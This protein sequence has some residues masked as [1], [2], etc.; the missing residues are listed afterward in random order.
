MIQ[1]E[2]S[3][4]QATLAQ[5]Y[6][7]IMGFLDSIQSNRN[8]GILVAVTVTLFAAGFVVSQG[9]SR[10]SRVVNATVFTGNS[11][12]I[13]EDD[14]S[15]TGYELG[16]R[17]TILPLAG[18]DG[19][20]WIVNAQQLAAEG[21]CRIRET[22]FDNAPYGREVH[23]SQC[24]IWWMVT[25]GKIHSSLT[26]MSHARSI[27]LM[28]IFST[29]LIFL[30]FIG[31]TAYLTLRRFGAIPAALV[32]LLVV[33]SVNFAGMFQVA[34]P[35]H[36]GIA[37]AALFYCVMLIAFAL[38]G[39]RIDS[40]KRRKIVY[41]AFFVPPI[42]YA[43]SRSYFLASGVAG[44]VALWISASTTI[45]ALIG[46]GGGALA[47]TL[48]QHWSDREADSLAS[49]TLLWRTWSLAGGSVSLLLYLMEYFPY[50][51]GW[52]LEVNHPIYSLAW[53]AAGELLFQTSTWIRQ[54]VNPLA[55]TKKLVVLF[56]AMGCVLLP[57][58]MIC[59][60]PQ[61]FFVVRDPFLWQLHSD[62][63]FEFAPLIR[64]FQAD[65]KIFVI[66]TLL[67][68]AFPIAF[69]FRTMMFEAIGSLWKRTLWFL[70][71]PSLI[72]IGLSLFQIRWLGLAELTCIPLTLISFVAHFNPTNEI[73]Y[74]IVDKALFTFGMFFLLS[75]VSIFV[76]EDRLGRFKND[77][78]SRSD[79]NAIYIRQLAHQLK[80]ENSDQELI[81]LSGP[82]DSTQLAYYGGFRCVGT[83]YWENLEGLKEAAKA[84]AAE[85]EQ[86]LKSIVLS[87][88][89]SHIVILDSETFVQEYPRLWRKYQQS[90]SSQETF[91]MSML[92]TEQYPPWIE[93]MSSPIDEAYGERKATVLKVKAT[94]K[95]F[96]P[97]R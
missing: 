14:D 64:C 37:S 31:S 25:L 23:W 8:K 93:R 9:T 16:M 97:D 49:T 68:I 44:G 1:S 59:L 76:I 94:P 26:G 69:T 66:W 29:P 30:M 46:I 72:C 53:L 84:F 11:I 35:D 40:R 89:I 2:G 74:S 60:W 58:L 56:V 52:R 80:R 61:R 83:L 96:K 86:E 79:A 34:V 65:M 6:H 15:P 28:A 42:T 77:M 41:P 33:N 55:S 82:A 67:G 12:G 92:K 19:M 71:V 45:P 39:S 20:H 50:H 5:D 10:F 7:S 91:L 70:L 13:K 36:H 57:G 27:E 3:S 90:S 78:L 32:V 85:S 73:R 18:L 24:L 21:K 95:Q 17:N 54:G 63:I 38:C 4:T 48:Y 87:R 62:Y 81:V 47:S 43:P 22:E 88:Q 75:P 51:L